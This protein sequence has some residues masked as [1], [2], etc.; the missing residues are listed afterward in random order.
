MQ[1]ILSL[2]LAVLPAVGMAEGAQLT[3]STVS[4]LTREKGASTALRQIY[5]SEKQWRE[6]LRNI[7]T[8]RV[9]WLN[10]ANE[11]RAAADAGGREQLELA[12]GEALEHRPSN[13]LRVA[14]PVFGVSVC[15]GPDIDD[16]RFDSY[17]R[18]IRAIVKRRKMLS[19]IPAP[20]LRRAR[21]LCMGE[22][23][24]SKV[25]IARFYGKAK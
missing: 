10:V 23:E 25:D 15:G 16:A 24:L 9:N 17:E 13:V 7:A 3:A 19:Q 5:E 20:N 6:L 18:S 21:D 1:A 8:G 11:L 4:K 22:L 14:F 12:V 2:V